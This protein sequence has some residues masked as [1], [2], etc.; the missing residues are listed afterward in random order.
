MDLILR[1]RIN[2]TWL[3]ST[4]LTWAWSMSLCMFESALILDAWIVFFITYNDAK[5]NVFIQ[6]LDT[7]ILRDTSCLGVYVH[8][9][10]VQL[11]VWMK[12][13]CIWVTADQQKAYCLRL[14]TLHSLACGRD[15]HRTHLRLIRFPLRNVST[16][17]HS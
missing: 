17:W 12:A 11:H 4:T 3:T 15:C 16:E 13:D 6:S 10:R 8:L 2:I 5:R 7:L 9:Q 14:F 1:H